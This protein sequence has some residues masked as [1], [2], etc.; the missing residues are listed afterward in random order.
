MRS[1]GIESVAFCEAMTSLRLKSG[2]SKTDAEICR[3]LLFQAIESH[4]QKCVEA[5]RGM[6]FERH[7]FGLRKMFD[8]LRESDGRYEKLDLPSI[9]EDKASDESQRW[10]VSTSGIKMEKEKEWCDGSGFGWVEERG[11]GVA[12]F[13]GEG[14]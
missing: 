10:H 7:L 14:R 9:F 13:L 1:V 2:K 6:G 12:Y 8:E 5:R 11:W 4:S 3:R